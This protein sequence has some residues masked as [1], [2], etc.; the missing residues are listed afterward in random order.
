M[1]KLSFGCLFVLG[2]TLVGEQRAS[3]W[4]DFKFSHAFNLELACGRSFMRIPVAQPPCF[5][6]SPMAPSL[7]YPM[8]PMVPVPA[9]P[10]PTKTIKPTDFQYPVLDGT[11]YQPVG[12]Y[13]YP[14][15]YYPVPSFWNG[16]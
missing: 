12:Y 16:Y 1:K 8:V 4:C 3:A 9:A 6:Q 7:G 14:A 13:P 5:P 10:A 15:P 2:L 11:G